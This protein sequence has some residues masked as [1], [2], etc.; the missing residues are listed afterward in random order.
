MGE[1]PQDQAAAA[2][3]IRRPA[4]RAVGTAVVRRA[5]RRAAVAQWLLSA[6]PNAREAKAEWDRYG[7][8]VLAC[9]GV[10]SAVRV[11]G[12][13][14][15]AAAGTEDHA[16]ADVFLTDW[17]DDGAVVMDRH[18]G[19]YYFLVP[20]LMGRLWNPKAFHKVECLGS[21]SYLGVPLVDHTIPEG[22]AYWAVE[23]DSPGAL[24]WPDEVA[25][26]L[27]RGQ[28]ALGGQ[29]APRP[30]PRLLAERFG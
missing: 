29:T 12:E 22:R 25:A 11:P 7:I 8:A 24:C 26:L 19:L 5:E 3:A 6:A 2:V 27:H 16:E 30:V 4:A 15:W 20:A 17:L 14:V 23:M 9:G 1:E 21:N 10:L 28:T 18:A 13:L